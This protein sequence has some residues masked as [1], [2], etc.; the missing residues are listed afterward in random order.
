MISRIT[1]KNN[2][3]NPI[4]GKKI[5]RVPDKANEVATINSVS[6]S[7][8]NT[9]K[10]AYM[11]LANR[12]NENSAL[13]SK[14]AAGVNNVKFDG[15]VFTVNC[16]ES[17]TVKFFMIDVGQR[18]LFRIKLLED[19]QLKNMVT[20]DNYRLVERINKN[21]FTYLT[22][23]MVNID[24][25]YNLID[26][27]Y[28]D[29]DETLLDVRRF[30]R[31]KDFE[32]IDLPQNVLTVQKTAK[33]Q[34]STVKPKEI[35]PGVTADMLPL[36]NKPSNN[37][38]QKM[39]SYSAII[40]AT[41]A[42]TSE[43]QDKLNK[44]NPINSNR[45][46]ELS[47]ESAAPKRGRP[48]KVESNEPKGVFTDVAKLSDLVAHISDYKNRMSE[49]YLLTLKK[50]SG[51]FDNN[52]L[53]GTKFKTPN[54]NLLLSEVNNKYGQFWKIVDY[55]DDYTV[56]SSFIID[57]SGKI[58]KNW[59]LKAPNSNLLHAPIFYTENE[60]E[61]LHLNEKISAS[62]AL[63]QESTNKFD[64]FIQ[65]KG[66]YGRVMDIDSNSYKL[67]LEVSSRVDKINDTYNTIQELWKDFSQ[68]YFTKLK[69][70]FDISTKRN[71]IY[72]TLPNKDV[73][74]IKKS[75]RK[76]FADSNFLDLTVYDPNKNVKFSTLFD[77]N[78]K[79]VSNVASLSNP[80]VKN[81]KY[82]SS[83]SA[84]TFVEQEDF[85]SV[86]N[87]AEEKLGAVCS[88]LQNND[89]N[90]TTRA[91]RVPK[92]LSLVDNSVKYD[93]VKITLD[94]AIQ[95]LD[96]ALDY[97]KQNFGIVNRFNEAVEKVKSDFNN[98]LSKLKNE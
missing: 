66:R 9:L 20:L 91:K 24:E 72:F 85:L 46:T 92:T 94:N 25:V 67:P 60:V 83:E 7:K 30:I 51:L 19:N 64:K 80:F 11:E 58:V 1:Y 40:Q 50:K 31:R 93:D 52:K 26:S 98:L 70:I 53:T 89:F 82:L 36:S 2:Y 23:S 48:H 45:T 4:F 96:D 55:N 74:A 47:S 63:M 62:L 97:I 54:S 28:D 43:V 95:E 84:K 65:G 41:K 18:K 29:V 76:N 90:K 81:L 77:G 33:E 87:M 38:A 68:F 12:A 22:N 61:Q 3:S 78:N 10:S 42:K 59:K 8:V 39:F 15:S 44:T 49:V 37:N 34:D 21:N 5:T 79:I 88:Y 13:A 35:L 71:A 17:K 86:L 75:S 14:L 57:K 56:N 16:D 69:D 27:V 73:L 32:A 6:L